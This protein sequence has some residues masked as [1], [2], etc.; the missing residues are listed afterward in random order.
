M[1]LWSFGWEVGADNPLN[2]LYGHPRPFTVI[3]SLKGE[4]QGE[5]DLSTIYERDPRIMREALPGA[6][7]QH[8]LEPHSR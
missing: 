5:D 4:Q 2:A 7:L 1:P 3:P 8:I 6:P